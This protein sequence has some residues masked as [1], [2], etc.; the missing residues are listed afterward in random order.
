M[1][2]QEGFGHPVLHLL[3]ARYF[4]SVALPQKP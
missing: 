4:G 3:A 2:V 1:T